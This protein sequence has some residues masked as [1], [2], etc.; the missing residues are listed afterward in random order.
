MAL[1]TRWGARA[2]RTGRRPSTLARQEARAGLTLIS[3]TVVIVLVIVIIPV[4]WTIMLSFQRIR[5]LNL[6]EAGIFGSYTLE[7]FRLVLTSPGFLSALTPAKRGESF[8]EQVCAPDGLRRWT[9]R[10]QPGFN[11]QLGSKCFL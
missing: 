3:P 10:T 4:L 5:L 11:R 1:T 7:N 8:H 6:R 2:R 9:C